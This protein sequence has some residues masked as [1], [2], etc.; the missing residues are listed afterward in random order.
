[1]DNR[2][3]AE[4]WAKTGSF[5]DLCL[6]EAWVRESA[7]IEDECDGRIEAGLGMR[8]YAA[9]KYD[10]ALAHVRQN[11]RQKMRVQ[12]ILFG[13]LRRWME[14]W[15][16]GGAFADTYT[17]ARELVRDHL[18][19]PTPEL[20][21]WVEAVLEEDTRLPE[22]AEK[23]IRAQTRVQLSK[24]MTEENQEKLVLVIAQAISD[25]IQEVRRANLQDGEAPAAAVSASTV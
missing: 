3:L 13:E 6:D 5:M 4:Q 23:P 1:M 11:L 12:S 14:E 19:Q 8:A 20:E 17:E 21:A 18:K 15:D 9:A 22:D 10:P 16:I 2:K 7:H 25:R 24:M